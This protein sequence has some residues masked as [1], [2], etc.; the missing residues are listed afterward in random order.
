ML[1]KPDINLLPPNKAKAKKKVET[2]N[3]YVR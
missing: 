3:Y 1:Q 2:Q